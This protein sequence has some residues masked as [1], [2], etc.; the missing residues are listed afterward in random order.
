ML[1][2]YLNTYHLCLMVML[3]FTCHQIMSLLL[4]TLWTHGCPVS[5]CSRPPR[6][7]AGRHAARYSTKRLA[8]ADGMVEGHLDCWSV[9]TFNGWDADGRSTQRSGW[10]SAMP[11]ARHKIVANPL[12]NH[13]KIKLSA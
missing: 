7:S 3:F 2:G 1:Y 4:R 11:F 10:P 5:G 13:C 9:T 6:T 12:Q 8:L